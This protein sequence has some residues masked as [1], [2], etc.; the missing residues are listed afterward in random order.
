MLKSSVKTPQKEHLYTL[1][2]SNVRDIINPL[3]Q[4]SFTGAMYDILSGST[5]KHVAY[6]VD[7]NTF[8]SLMM[9]DENGVIMVL[10]FPYDSPDTKEHYKHELLNIARRRFGLEPEL[11]AV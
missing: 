5:H 2:G 7:D 3:D 9:I 8:I 1:A 11:E 10:E 6:A 4:Q